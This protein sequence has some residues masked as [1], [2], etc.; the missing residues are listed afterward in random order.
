MNEW[1][2]I[3][4]VEV[5]EDP[6]PVW[7]SVELS[8][9]PDCC[10][11]QELGQICDIF[12]DPCCLNPF[13]STVWTEANVFNWAVNIDNTDTTG[14]KI[15]H[16]VVE[17]DKG[18]PENTETSLPKCKTKITKREWTINA[19]I[20]CTDAK[21]HIWGDDPVRTGNY[22]SIDNLM[23]SIQLGSLNF[24]FWFATLGGYIYGDVDGIQP[25]YADAYV[26]HENDKTSVRTWTLVLKFSALVDSRRVPNPLASV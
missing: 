14:T 23:R 19:Q 21:Y 2:D 10:T 24:C 26:T 22:G 5:C 13:P 20:K 1:L 3:E 8:D 4:E 9:D 11:E 12:L 18:Q 17:G 25:S 6:C 16:I 7:G 15:K